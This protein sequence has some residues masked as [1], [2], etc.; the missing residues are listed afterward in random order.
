MSGKS[1]LG[2][3]QVGSIEEQERGIHV[4]EVVGAFAAYAVEGR[5]GVE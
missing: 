3:G 1:C 4:A 5:C 2:G